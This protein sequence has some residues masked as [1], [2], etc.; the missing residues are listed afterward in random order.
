MG[1]EYERNYKTKVPA[2]RKG[3]LFRDLVRAGVT[4]GLKKKQI[5]GRVTRFVTKVNGIPVRITIDTEP[6]DWYK[7]HPNH[8]KQ[9]KEYWKE[10][11]GR[12]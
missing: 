8:S 12:K 1:S 10:R 3:N 6:Y 11:R 2:V 7:K 9:M 5:W 4:L